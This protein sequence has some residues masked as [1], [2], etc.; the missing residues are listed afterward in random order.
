MS[1]IAGA[2]SAEETYKEVRTHYVLQGASGTAVGE[3]TKIYRFSDSWDRMFVVYRSAG[4][5]ELVIEQGI[6]FESKVFDLAIRDIKREDWIAAH[7]KVPYA[8]NT[9]AE[10]LKSVDQNMK[11]YEAMTG[12]V[13]FETNSGSWDGFE[14]DWT[15]DAKVA[16]T[17]QLRR[18]TRFELL[19]KLERTR[20]LFGVDDLAIGADYILTYLM[21][22]RGCEA[23][24]PTLRVEIPD[25]DFDRSLGFA[26]SEKQ[27]AKATRGVTA[28]GN[29]IKRY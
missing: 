16:L 22:E 4:G 1:L 19:E 25:C 11:L 7:W 15:G 5:D 17:K 13:T 29:P 26:C 3:A 9:R 14:K 6:D 18:G 20:A 12:F 27:L 23:P 21:Y 8:G 24:G 10:G 2:V 28:E